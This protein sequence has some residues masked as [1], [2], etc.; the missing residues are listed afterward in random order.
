LESAFETLADGLWR[1]FEK[2]WEKRFKE[3][4]DLFQKPTP[5]E[6]ELTK[7]REDREARRLAEERSQAESDLAKAR[8]EG[9]PEKIAAAERRVREIEDDERERTLEKKAEAER[10]AADDELARKRE[11]L[12]KAKEIERRKLQDRINVIHDLLARGK[13]SADEAR[14]R[15]G[16]V[17]K[18]FDLDLSDAGSGIQR[19]MNDVIISFTELTNVLERL[20]ATLGGKPASG[21][22]S[23][24]GTTGAADGFE[25]AVAAAFK[26]GGGGGAGRV[27]ALQHGGII[28]R[29]VFPALLGERGPE[30]VI[31]LS[32]PRAAGL[33][34]PPVV[35]LYFEN[36]MEWLRQFVRVEV[37]GRT[38]ELT[39]RIGR[40]AYRRLREGRF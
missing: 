5:A 23:P 34:E 9:D 2:K 14:R 8:E 39:A 15:I 19:V 35:N 1:A 29:P 31:P 26:G 38:P 12:D 25:R 22:R 7:F 10:K 40:E 11:S 21:G 6:E 20:N 28:T 32:S 16:D 13:I 33:A 37:D 4:D 27:L 18:D 24:R 3:L 17:W 30:A 36:G